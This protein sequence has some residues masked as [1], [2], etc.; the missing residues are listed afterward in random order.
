MEVNT[1]LFEFGRYL[2]DVFL[3]N[4]PH[5]FEQAGDLFSFLAS[6][7]DHIH[8]EVRKLYPEAEL[9]GFESEIID[10]KHMQL[11]YYSKRKMSEFALGLI[12]ASMKHF[13]EEGHTK[14]VESKKDGA[15]VLFEIA[16]N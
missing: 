1:L 10:E 8:V 4:Y 2:F 16:L 9:P 15:E 11:K 13:G 6:I 12:S 7:E 3:K 5:F 14:I